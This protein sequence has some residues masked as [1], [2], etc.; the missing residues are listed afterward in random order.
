MQIMQ[1]FHIFTNYK[2]IVGSAVLCDAKLYQ[3]KRRNLSLSK[4]THKRAFEAANDEFR[5]QE[6]QS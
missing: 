4:V 6:L 1:Y 5:E 2:A 3:S